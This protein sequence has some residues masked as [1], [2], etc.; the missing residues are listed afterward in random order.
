MLVVAVLPPQY[1][2]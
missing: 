1:S 2:S